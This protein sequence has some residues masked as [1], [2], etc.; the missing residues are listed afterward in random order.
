MATTNHVH[1]WKDGDRLF[2]D[3]NGATIEAESLT[4]DQHVVTLQFC[5]RMTPTT[6]AAVSNNKPAKMG[7]PSVVDGDPLLDE[8]MW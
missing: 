6:T 3:L 4:V 1:C 8:C 7:W 5:G 2:V